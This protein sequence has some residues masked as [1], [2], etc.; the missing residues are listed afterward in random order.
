MEEILYKF[1]D[2]GKREHEEMRAFISEFQTTN[3]SLFKERNNSLSELRFEVQELLKRTARSD[4]VKSEHL[5]SASA[6]EIDEK[7]PELKSLPNHLE[8]ASLQGDKYFPIIISSKLSEKEKKLLLQDAKPRLI[9]WVLLLQG[10]DIEI[11]DK[12]GAEN[13]AADHLSRFENPDLGT[14][15]EDEIANEFFKEHLMILKAEL[16]DDEP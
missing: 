6:N 8:Y 10:F 14:F 3:E 16:S 1:I 7:R 2:E 9:S 15:I 4:E 13:L 12:K 5:Y 11:K